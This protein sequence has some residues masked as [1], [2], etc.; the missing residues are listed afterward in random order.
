MGIGNHRSIAIAGAGVAGLAL[1][2]RLR[3]SGHG[4]TVFEAR[5]HAGLAEG[6]FL[7]LAPNGMNALRLIGADGEV[8]EAGIATTAI[9][10][11][12]ERGRRLALMDQSDHAEAFG[13]HSVTIRRGTLADILIR[14]AEE[15]GVTLHFGSRIVGVTDAPTGVSVETAGGTWMGFDLLAA[16]DG[17]RSTVR[18]IAFPDYPEPHFTGLIG[19]GGFVEVPELAPTDGTMRMTFG[20]EAFFGYIKAPGEPVYWFDSYPQDPS[21]PAPADPR[22]YAALLRR[23]HRDDP[24][25]NREI[26]A[27]VEGIDRDYPIFDMPALPVWHRGNVVLVGDAAHAVGPHAGQGASIAIE[28]AIVLAACIEAEAA[29]GTA[30]ARNERLR[31]G[32]VT[33]VV[34][35]TARNGA[36][37]RA[38]SRLALMIRNL[39]L[40]F[41]LPLGIRAARRFYAYRIDLDPLGAPAG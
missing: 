37:K 19:T 31:R 13:A 39:V 33:E 29:N 24:R 35:Q 11:L 34:K 5:D 41:V 2:I 8:A 6:V 21:A 30:F 32:R 23:L 28:D 4:V 38:N 9:E 25:E 40:P 36:Q 12:D 17:L 16:C 10:I 14:H 22:A 3:Q 15:A 27:G 26:L 20:R 1:A 18:R 7:T